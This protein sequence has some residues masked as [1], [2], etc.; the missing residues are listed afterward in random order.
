MRPHLLYNTASAFDIVHRRISLPGF[1]WCSKEPHPS[2]LNGSRPSSS[3]QSPQA[4]PWYSSSPLRSSLLIA[5]ASFSGNHAT[6]VRIRFWNAGF[7]ADRRQNPPRPP[8]MNNEHSSRNLK[9][10]ANPPNSH[11]EITPTEATVIS[12]LDS[13]TSAVGVETPNRNA[14]GSYDSK[15]AAE[16]ATAQAATSLFQSTT[17]FIPLLLL[18][19]H[20]PLC[21]AIGVVQRR[22]SNCKTA[23][24]SSFIR[25][26]KILHNK[27]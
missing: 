7:W 27:H 16:S 11:T 4:T 15:S 18:P 19:P 2:S 9:Q 25:H 1:N 17:L 23:R 26:D 6:H 22:R 3:P 10:E 20:L 5:W 12:A 21:T 14:S 8:T 13:I 24:S